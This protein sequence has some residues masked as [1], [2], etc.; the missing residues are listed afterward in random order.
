MTF[1]T[2]FSVGFSN[3]L[4]TTYQKQCGFAESINIW[5]TELISPE[6][7]LEKEV[8]YEESIMD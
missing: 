5:K 2:N 8:K 1:F 4:A 6:E 3:A 7:D